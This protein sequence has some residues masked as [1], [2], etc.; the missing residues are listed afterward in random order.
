MRVKCV[1]QEHT[2]M[3][4]AMAQT[5]TAR[6]KGQCSNHAATM[7]VDCWTDHWIILYNYIQFLGFYQE[8]QHE[9]TVHDQH[10]LKGS[11]NQSLTSLVKLS[12]RIFIN[13]SCFSFSS[14]SLFSFL[15]VSWRDE[16]W[17]QVSKWKKTPKY[18]NNIVEKLT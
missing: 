14:V 10:V 8:V 1:S 11:K 6:S 15:L 5:L 7:P 3:S 17:L 12:S 16:T 18:N 2:K 9:K 13:C 4:L